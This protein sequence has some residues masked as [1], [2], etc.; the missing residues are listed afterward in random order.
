MVVD[1]GYFTPWQSTGEPLPNLVAK[2]DG[3]SLDN[4]L[5]QL[6]ITMWKT[7]LLQTLLFQPRKTG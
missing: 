1:V 5:R 3:T 2:S 4:D 7:W 6:S